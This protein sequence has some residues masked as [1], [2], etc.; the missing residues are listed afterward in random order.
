MRTIRLLDI[1]S[2]PSSIRPDGSWSWTNLPFG[3][4][5]EVITVRAFD[6]LTT[7]WNER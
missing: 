6:L 2:I 5:G 7:R 3:G 1:A 4:G